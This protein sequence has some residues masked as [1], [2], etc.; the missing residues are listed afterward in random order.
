MKRSS[1][2]IKL[3]SVLMICAMGMALVACGSDD[4][5]KKKGS[6]STKD[7]AATTVATTTIATTV[8]PTFSGPMT[9]DVAISWVETEIEGGSTVMYVNCTEDYIN[10]RKGPETTYDVVAKLANK[11]P[12]TVVAQTETGWYKTTDGFYVSGGLLSATNPQ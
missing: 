3:G 2:V 4:K 11:M 9:N 12:V 7:T 5:E 8:I 6:D 10:V 1:L